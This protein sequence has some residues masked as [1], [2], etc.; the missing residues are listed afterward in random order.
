MGN[1]DTGDTAWMLIATA[2]VFFMIPGLGFFEAGLIRAKNSLNVI[3]QMWTGA[4]V[5]SVLYFCVGFTLIFSPGKFIGGW[6]YGFM[7]NVPTQDS[8]PGQTVPALLFALFQMM[9]FDITPLLISG[10]WVERFKWRPFLIFIVCWNLLVYCFVAHWIWGNGFMAD[11]G[12]IDFA[13]GIVIHTTAGVSSLVTALMLGRR[14]HFTNEVSPT[15]VNEAHNIPLSILGAGM[16]WFGWFGFNGGS[17]IGS[18]TVSTA[19]MFNSQIAS[20]TAGCT[21]LIIGMI[22]EKRASSVGIITGSVAGL[23]CITPASGYVSVQ[24]A[25]ALGIVAGVAS[26]LSIILLKEKLRIDDA[27]DVSSVHGLTG[28]IGSVTAGIFAT[29]TVN[30]SGPDR[31]GK[32][33]GY[34]FLAVLISGAWAGFWTF[35]ILFVMKRIPHVGLTTSAEKQEAGLDSVYHKELAYNTVDGE[36]IYSKSSVMLKQ[37]SVYKSQQQDSVVRSN[38]DYAGLGN[39]SASTS[40]TTA[41]GVTFSEGQVVVPL[42]SPAVAPFNTP[43]ETPNPSSSATQIVRV[44]VPLPTPE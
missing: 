34:Q 15:E 30:P 20:S 42:N 14:A 7:M 4:C 2:L 11:W 29:S 41:A 37:N 38:V 44:S 31:S 40:T 8:F 25:F 28:M 1:I 16:L 18:N 27:L 19:A 43:A 9:F 36:S 35:A 26:Y 6:T 12:V 3:M 24:C 5:L 13:G 21:W 22:R 23:A 17:A 10:A 33:V 39:A 32:L